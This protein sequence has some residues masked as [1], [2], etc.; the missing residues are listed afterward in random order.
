M[1]KKDNFFDKAF[2]TLKDNVELTEQQKSTMLNNILSEC[3][4]QKVTGIDK[5]KEFITTYPW[6][7]A[8]A[9]STV[10]AFIFTIAFGTQYT[11]LFL[12]FFG[13]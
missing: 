1:A 13:G 10:Q 6:R 7:F 11:N 9:L 4:R 5:I 2:D 8:F 3:H 12:S